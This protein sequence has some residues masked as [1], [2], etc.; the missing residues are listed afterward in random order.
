MVEDRIDNHVGIVNGN[1]TTFAPSTARNLGWYKPLARYS[2]SISLNL[3]PNHICL[4]RPRET[5][6]NSHLVFKGF[7]CILL[8]QCII[9]QQVY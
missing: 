3:L 9:F 5:T 2:H 6:V 1:L 4:H 8:C 7:N